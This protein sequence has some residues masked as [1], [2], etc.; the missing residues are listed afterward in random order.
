MRAREAIRC[1]GKAF[2]LDD[3]MIHSPNDAAN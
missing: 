3:A 2:C 1:M